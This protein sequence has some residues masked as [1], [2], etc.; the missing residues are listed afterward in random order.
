MVFKTKR[1]EVYCIVGR[2]RSKAMC[3]NKVA[4]VR[5]HVGWC[6]RYTVYIYDSGSIVVKILALN[7]FQGQGN[8][9]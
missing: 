8:P 3:R 4:L 1:E 6:F 5:K 2:H 7:G 9:C